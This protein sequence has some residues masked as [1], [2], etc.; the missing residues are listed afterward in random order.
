MVQ[1]T[2][3]LL[4]LIGFNS[5][6]QLMKDTSLLIDDWQPIGGLKDGDVGTGPNQIPTGQPTVGS[7]AFVDNVATLRPFSNTSVQPVFPGEVV[8][9]LSADGTSLTF[10]AR[11]FS[12]ADANKP[13]T[14]TTITLTAV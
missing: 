2:Y 7:M 13:I 3:E 5:V 14:E 10:R 8:I 1:R 4:H 11:P 9:A 12:P 6:T